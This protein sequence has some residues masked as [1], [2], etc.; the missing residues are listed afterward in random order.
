[1][2]PT[3]AAGSINTGIVG[4]PSASNYDNIITAE[5]NPCILDNIGCI[6]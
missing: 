6:G 2:S 4:R 3:W 1:M 5:P